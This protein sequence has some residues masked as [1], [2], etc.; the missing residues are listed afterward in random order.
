MTGTFALCHLFVALGKSLNSSL[1]I[2]EGELNLYFM[3]LF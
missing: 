2:S 3:G 1:F